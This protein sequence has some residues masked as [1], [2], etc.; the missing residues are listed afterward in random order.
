MAVSHLHLT[1]GQS[2]PSAALIK[3][4]QTIKTIIF[5]PA[6]QGEVKWMG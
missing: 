2:Y 3:W 4:L 1:G 6:M 5:A